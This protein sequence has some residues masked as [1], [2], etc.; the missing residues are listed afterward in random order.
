[1]MKMMS[2]KKAVWLVGGI[3]LLWPFVG[4]GAMVILEDDSGP[5]IT[6]VDLED[7]LLIVG[8][9]V[10]VTHKVAE[11]LFGAANTVDINSD[12]G[13]DLH[14]AGSTVRINGSVGDDLFAG[15]NTVRVT[16]SSV[17]DV[18]A[19]GNLVEIIADRVEGSV[20]A[21]GQKVNIK[22][23]I[24]GSVRTGAEIVNIKSGTKIAG[25]L[26]TLGTNEPT[27]EEGVE[28]S[29]E[30][31]HSYPDRK[32]G[33][34]E[35][36]LIMAWV[37]SVLVWFAVAVVLVYLLPSFVKDIVGTALTKG[38]KSLGV[39]F[40]WVALLLP[41]FVIL[42]IT[43]VGWP[44]A[45][46]TALVTISLLIAAYAYSMVVVGSWIMRRVKK[47]E[48]KIS[49]QHILLGVVIM[50]VVSIVPV[51]GWLV[52]VVVVLLTLGATVLVLW[53]RLKSEKVVV[54]EKV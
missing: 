17:D 4:Y 16:V 9:N 54:S 15:G 14:V 24:W 2:R 35:R 25:D 38:G 22:G 41:V 6:S 49:W 21:G 50:R 1:M 53:E 8:N 47:V 34:T 51:V 29:G 44:L 37:A 31:R 40:V 45:I 33:R 19:A 27:I 20:Y 52:S 11:D 5:A 43:F 30:V 26:I 18:F 7:D 13:Q 39:G 32:A 48:S 23:D 12:I 46:M 10:S 3:M 42:M 28:I 36:N